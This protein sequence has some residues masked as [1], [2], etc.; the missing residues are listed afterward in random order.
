MTFSRR[1]FLRMGHAATAVAFAGIAL[2][3]CT[4]NSQSDTGSA[5]NQRAELNAS[6]DATL[7]KLYQ[8]SSQ[9][10]NL[11]SQAKGVLIFPSVISASFIVGGQYGKG[12]LRQ[13]G[14]TVAYYSTVTGS[15][16]FQAGAQSRATVLLFMTDQALADFKKSDGW[17]VGADAT[18]AIA[19]I[20]ANGSI[21]TNTMK[22]PIVGF[23]L[24]NAG[25][26][27]GVSIDGTKVTRDTS[28]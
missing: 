1:F 14:K 19:K 2:T 21:D 25:L 8:S 17:T 15:L 5:A 10:Q 18:V 22:Q 12:V 9:A 11:V 26:M 3:G 16:G 13:Q 27:A 4:T 24:N 23:V 7:S 6:S 28:L 20:G